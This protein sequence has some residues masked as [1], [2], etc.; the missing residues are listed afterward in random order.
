MGVFMLGCGFELVWAVSMSKLFMCIVV[1]SN[2]LGGFDLGT[3]GD[4]LEGVKLVVLCWVVVS[5]ELGVD[6]V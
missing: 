2:S 6:C 5:V 1:S 3:I 4:R